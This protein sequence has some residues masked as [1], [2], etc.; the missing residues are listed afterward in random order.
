MVP[1]ANSHVSIISTTGVSGSVCRV[2]GTWVPSSVGSSVVDVSV[3]SL[4]C[5][6][7]DKDICLNIIP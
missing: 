6:M 7:P 2:F 4:V 5:R 3:L 1:R